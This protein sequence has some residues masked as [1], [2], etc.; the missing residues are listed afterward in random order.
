MTEL[1]IAAIMFYILIGLFLADTF[2]VEVDT[3]Y[4]LFLIFYPIVILCF[5]VVL[6]VLYVVSKIYQAGEKYL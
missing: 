5:F 2:L 1:Q 6:L 4:W 3:T